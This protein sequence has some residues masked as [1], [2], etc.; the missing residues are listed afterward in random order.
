MKTTYPKDFLATLFTIRCQVFAIALFTVK[1]ACKKIKEY[2][3]RRFTEPVK[4]QFLP[5]IGLL[6]SQAGSTLM[7]G[8]DMHAHLFP[9]KFV[10]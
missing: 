3:K 2:I 7:Y 5:V 9:P 10:S 4:F 1:V 8:I 6:G